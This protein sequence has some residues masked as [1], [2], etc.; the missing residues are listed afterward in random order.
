MSIYF[1]YPVFSLQILIG[2]DFSIMMERKFELESEGLQWVQGKALVEGVGE[3]H[4][5]RVWIW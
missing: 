5:S 1:Y 4:P 3:K 2:G